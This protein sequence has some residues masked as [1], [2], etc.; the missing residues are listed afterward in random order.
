MPLTVYADILVLVNLYIDF[1][2]LWVVKKFLGL[3]AGKFRLALGAL[4][5]GLCSLTA[6]L[7]SLPSVLSLLIGLCAAL[8]ITAAAFFPLS[9]RSLLRA[10]LYFWAFTLLLAG[11][12]LFLLR[13]L[14]PGKVAV[15]GNVVYFDLSPLLLFLFTCGA[16]LVLELLRR[17]FP[18]KNQSLRCCWITLEYGGKSQRI[19][20][21]ADTGNALRE[22]FSG[23]PVIVCQAKSLQG[24]V[25]PELL[26]FPESGKLAHTEGI[27]L[28][29]VETVSGTGVLPAFRP[30]R[31]VTEQGQ[32]LE[33]YIALCRQPLSAGQYDALY[34]P[35]LFPEAPSP[36][37]RLSGGLP[38]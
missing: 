36:S 32:V 26:E 15:L 7:P 2:L 13:F 9:A 5:G 28:I 18:G 8:L 34:N 24:C 1:F 3:R 20:A 21:K 6:L 4:I 17:F 30:E 29:P 10:A 12:F 19:F 25:P 16:Y 14:A 35:D 38:K 31:A 33:C 22:P 23:L 37:Q 27:R 11:F